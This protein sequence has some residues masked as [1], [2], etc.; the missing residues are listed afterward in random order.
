MKVSVIIVNYKTARL[1]VDC[2]RSIHAHTEGLEYEVIVVDNASGDGLQD[3]M[4]SEFGDKVQCVMLDSNVGFGMANNAG[5]AVARGQYLFCLNPDTLLLGNAISHLSDYLDAHAD[6]GACGGNLYDAAMRP[7]Y[8]FY[9]ALPGLRYEFFI[10]SANKLPMLIYGG[11]WCH[12][13]S[14]HPLRVPCITGADL[15]LRR[16]VVEQTGGFSPDYFM[17]YEETDLCA[18][19]S[20]LGWSIV[21]VPWA[22]IQHLEGASF[23]SGTSVNPRRY[24]M[25]ESSRRIYMRR[26]ASALRRWLCDQIYYSN[27]CLYHGLFALSGSALARLYAVRREA[28]KTASKNK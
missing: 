20:A 27:L 3:V 6:V 4:R 12:N 21:S 10:L 8:S 22:R 2:I 17:Y 19:I 15:M 7:A 28:F 14:G 16:E 13:H 18:R 25:M 9:R 24:E 5:F 26:H 23:A 1:I 11:N